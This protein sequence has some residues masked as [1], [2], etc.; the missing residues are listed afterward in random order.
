MRSHED[1]SLEARDDLSNDHTQIRFSPDDPASLPWSE[2]LSGGTSL[3]DFATVSPPYYLT[4]LDAAAAGEP[5]ESIAS[6]AIFRGMTGSAF[7]IVP[8]R[9]PIASDIGAAPAASNFA[10]PQNATIVLTDQ[11]LTIAAGQTIS[12]TADDQY[13]PAAISVSPSGSHFDSGISIFNHGSIISTSAFNAAAATGIAYQEAGMGLGEALQND[14]L[15]QVTGTGNG[16]SATGVFATGVSPAFTNLASGQ[17]I[18]TGASA[19]GYTGNP[20]QASDGSL[21]GYFQNAGVITVTATG[22]DPAN[23][24]GYAVGAALKGQ[25]FYALNTGTVTVHAPEGT[26]PN[27][28]GHSAYGFDFEDGGEVDNYGTIS[29]SAD[30]HNELT[31]AIRNPSIV[32]N[33]GH[34]S[35]GYAIYEGSVQTQGTFIAENYGTMDGTVSMGGGPDIVVNQGTINGNVLLGDGNDKFDGT[36]GTLHG[37][38]DGGEGNDTLIGS[39]GNDTLLGGIGDDV[40]I[41]GPGNDTLDGGDGYDTAVFSGVRSAYTITQNGAQTIVSGPDGTDTLTNIE[42]LQFADSPVAPSQGLTINILYDSS[43]DS[44]PASFKATVA[45]AVHYLETNFSD[46]ITLNIALGYGEIDG[47]PLDS[48]ALAESGSNI[49][50]SG[51]PVAIADLRADAKSSADATA[52]ASI[53]NSDPTGGTGLLLMTTAQAQAIGVPVSQGELDGVIGVS[54]TVTFDYDPS[55]G[56]NAGQYDLFGALVHELSEIMGRQLQVGVPDPNYGSNE[57]LYDLFHYAAPGVRSFVGTTPGYF[58]IDGGNTDLHDFNTDTSGDFGDW[59]SSDGPDAFDAFV[60]SGTV[61]PISQADLTALDVIGWDAATANHTPVVVGNFL[62]AAP[63]VSIPITNLF[64]YSDADGASDI[65]SFT[66]MGGS[67]TSYLTHNGV[68]FPV[69]LTPAT[70][71]ISDLANWAYVTAPTGSGI[72]QLRVTDS[73]GATNT[74]AYATVTTSPTSDIPPTGIL[75]TSGTLT[76]GQVLT[77]DTS[78][79]QDTDGLGTFHYQWHHYTDAG[80]FVNVGTDQATYTLTGADVG[81]HMNVTVSYVDGHGNFESLSSS[82]GAPVQGLPDSP[83]TGAVVVQGSVAEDATLSANTSTLADADGLGTLHYQW[84]RDGGAGFGNV[85]S[86]QATYMLGDADVAANIRVVVSYT[87]GHGVNESVTSAAVGPVANVNDPPVLAG[88][89]NTLGYTEQGAPVAIDPALTVSD[90]DSTTLASATVTIASGFVAGDVLGFTGQNGISA[91]YDANTHVLTLGGVASVA[92]Y[93]AALRSV[94]FS[95][96]SD[97]PTNFGAY[98][99]RTIIWSADDG[100]SANHA[101]N[102]VSSTVA[103]T[104]VD[105]PA[106][107]HN[108]AFG[109]LETTAIGSGLSLFADNGSGADSDPDGPALQIGAVNG[110]SANVGDQIALSSGALL[111]VHA[112]GS[113]AYDPNHAFDYLAGPGSGASDVSATDMFN[114]TLVGGSIGT[115]SVSIAGVDSNDVLFGTPG[116]DYLDGGA[117]YDTASYANATSGVH[118]SLAITGPQDTVGAG[119]DTLINIEYLIGSAYDD[120]LSGNGVDNVYLEGDS[121]NDTLI[122]GVGDDYLIGGTGNDVLQGGAGNDMF[123][124]TKGDGLDT[125]VDFSPGSASGDVLD[126]NGYGIASFSALQAFM[127]QVGADT[128]IAFDP[129]N[130]ITLHNVQMSQLNSG[131]FLFG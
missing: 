130:H 1:D 107:A 60:S 120:T 68:K 96:S 52:M 3:P 64:S 13:S 88:G 43:V 42:N 35:G 106:V 4:P 37:T 22:A 104:A 76:Q 55:N 63:R 72:L 77:A 7:E 11:D 97:N 126:L 80:G 12:H 118:V 47:N 46:P 14:G 65:V 113:F 62:T 123:V 74:Y 99:S 54:N 23:I 27:G 100:A 8:S 98:P 85:G 5:A 32:I 61:E 66:L 92:N 2:T 82:V 79:L 21:S 89:G 24:Y 56:I 121:G 109:T 78:A 49:A 129:Q 41:G 40:L 116:N 110:L 18:A 131:D 30:S 53:P 17:I 94:T 34:I 124:F 75:K 28:F 6:F 50:P 103:V 81:T 93:Q 36:G 117:G 115:A 57:L 31:V 19:Y 25:P 111:T 84:Q 112:D 122:G 108:D 102:N 119:T 71:P 95:S 51:Y 26:D 16:T 114:Y 91:S 67:A 9:P 20:P 70:G 44:A 87:D 33:H 90:V 38:V 39:S 15:I 86:D 59:A 29:A 69:G 10:D 101:S 73:H 128:L 105:D 125:I 83:P 58:S 48:G 127:S 45:A